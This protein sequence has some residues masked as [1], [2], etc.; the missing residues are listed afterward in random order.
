MCSSWQSSQPSPPALDICT[1]VNLESQLLS[2]MESAAGPPCLALLKRLLN[3]SCQS[4]WPA[5]SNGCSCSAQAEVMLG[6]GVQQISWA[7]WAGA[8]L[9]SCPALS[10][11][12]LTGRTAGLRNRLGPAAGP[13][14]V[15]A[16]TDLP[17]LATELRL[18]SGSSCKPAPCSINWVAGLPVGAQTPQGL[19]CFRPVGIKAYRLQMTAMSGKLVQTG[20]CML[21]AGTSDQ[22]DLLRSHTVA[23]LC[24]TTPA[25]DALV[26]RD[27][28]AGALSYTCMLCRLKSQSAT[29]G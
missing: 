22:A 23:I 17:F 24:P 6:W 10:Q 27:T 13:C 11:A 3:V 29:Q 1:R 4:P 12:R 8:S 18:S 5:W 19:P 21:S 14:P 26:L 2:C 25:K 7:G 28:R 15:L 20:F 16:V 9:L